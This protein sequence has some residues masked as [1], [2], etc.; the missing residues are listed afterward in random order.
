MTSI[1]STRIRVRE[2]TSVSDFFRSTEVS[3][4]TLLNPGAQN[5]EIRQI[6]VEAH[7]DTVLRVVGEACAGT[8]GRT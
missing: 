8:Y 4:W 6:L 5:N 1:E 7:R 2:N 3:V